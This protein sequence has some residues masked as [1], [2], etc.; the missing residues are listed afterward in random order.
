MYVLVPSVVAF[1]KAET[2]Q[3][4]DLAWLS[5]KAGDLG[6]WFSLV[7]AT[8]SMFWLGGEAIVSLVVRNQNI[9]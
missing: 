1:A 9:L 8:T 7:P 6:V 5:G 3:E 4:F 2:V